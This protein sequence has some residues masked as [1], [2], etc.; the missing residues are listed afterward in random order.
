MFPTDKTGDVLQGPRP[1]Q[2]VHRDEV[3]K[4][5]RLQ[6]PHVLLHARRFILENTYSFTPLEKFIGLFIIYWKIIWIKLNTMTLLHNTHRILDQRK[7]FQTQKVHFEQAGTFYYGVVKLGAKHVRV[8]GQGHRNKIGNVRWGY[9]YPTSMDPCIPNGSFQHLR[10]IDG[11][12]KVI[13]AFGDPDQLIGFFYT[14][15]TVL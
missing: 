6:L 12:G 9:N 15:R 14:F 10:L 2:S 3:R 8:F 11:P 1:V 4:H 5:G 7:R 13:I